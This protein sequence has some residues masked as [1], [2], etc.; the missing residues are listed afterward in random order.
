MVASSLTH[1]LRRLCQIGGMR[2]IGIVSLHIFEVGSE[3]QRFGATGAGVRKAGES[4]VVQIDRAQSGCASASDVGRCL[5]HIKLCS[6]SRRKISSGHVERLIRRLQ[7]LCFTL[8]YAVGSLKIEKSA[9]D[10]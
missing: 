7:V 6:Q 3:I 10:F 1:F 5:Q 4:N 8:E 9:A 2:G